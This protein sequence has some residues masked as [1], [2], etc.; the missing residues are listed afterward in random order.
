MGKKSSRYVAIPKKED[1]ERTIAT[2]PTTGGK[3]SSIME[4]LLKI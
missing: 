1:A 4:S 2:F 3:E